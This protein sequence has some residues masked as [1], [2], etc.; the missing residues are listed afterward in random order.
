M[1]GKYSKLTVAIALATA[2]SFAIL[3]LSATAQRCPLD[4]GQVQNQ[5]EILFGGKTYLAQTFVP[6]ALG[7]RVCNIKVTIR[8]INTKAGPLTLRL[9]NPA[10]GPMADPVTIAPAAIPMGVSVQLFDF[11][12]NDA[13]LNGDFHAIQLE[14]PNSRP[15]DYAWRGAGGNPYAKPGNGGKGWRNLNA[16]VGGSWSS[17]GMWDYTF[18]VH[19]CD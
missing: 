18:E 3:P 12:C 8:K 11:G 15:G 16:G 14:S 6:S 9:L 13:P 7:R 2:L 1:K 4:Q 10:F 5:G 17:L 19:M